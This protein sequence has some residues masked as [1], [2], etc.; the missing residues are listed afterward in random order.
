MSLAAHQVLSLVRL[1]GS[2]T[3][4]QFDFTVRRGIAS[5]GDPPFPI[6]GLLC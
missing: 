1:P 4:A 6:V 5:N 2:A 3:P